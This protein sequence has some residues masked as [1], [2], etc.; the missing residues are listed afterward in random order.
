M[1]IFFIIHT[2]LTYG[3]Q[4][5]AKHQFGVNWDYHHTLEMLN[6]TSFLLNYLSDVF[7]G[8]SSYSEWMNTDLYERTKEKFGVCPVPETL[9]TRLNMASYSPD[10]A[11]KFELNTS[12]DWLRRRQGVALPI[13]PPI[14]LDARKHFF[15]GI[16]K[17]AGQA[18][19]AGKKKIDFEAFAREWN[20]S[21]DGKTRYYVTGDV[22]TTLPFPESLKGNATV[23]QLHHGLFA[24]GDS[25]DQEM[26]ESISVDLAISHPR[27]V[28]DQP[29]NTSPRPTQSTLAAK[30][31]NSVPQGP[32][33]TDRSTSCDPEIYHREP[34][35]SQEPG[36]S[37]L[38][39]DASDLQN[40]SNMV[41]DPPHPV[42]DCQVV[43]RSIT[44]GRRRVVPENE[45][46][47][48]MRT[49]RRGRQK[50]LIMGRSARLNQVDA[51]SM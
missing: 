50:G 17:F 2:C 7:D 46:K 16:R 12:D 13:L 31:A 34:G 20:S 48:K 26:P 49:C 5:F 42:S 6:R 47:N 1:S 39:L 35:P 18:S 40:N 8:A 45:R 43:P 14:T 21:A 32:P 25:E 29:P 23:A 10:A 15:T 24:L 11:S 51:S 28:R 36:G 33:N 9:R 41:I 30:T 4:A 44:Q 22:L 19:T 37:N 3:W 27:I 38:G